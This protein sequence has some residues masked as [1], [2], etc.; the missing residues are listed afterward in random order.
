MTSK[1]F[2][3]NKRYLHVYIHSISTDQFETWWII[4]VL[5]QLLSWLT[6]H[7]ASWRVFNDS[8]GRRKIWLCDL[9]SLTT[10]ANREVLVQLQIWPCHRTSALTLRA[11]GKPA[12]GA[13]QQ[14]SYLKRE[15]VKMGWD[16][17]TKPVSLRL[18][19]MYGMTAHTGTS[20]PRF[21]ALYQGGDCA[22]K[23]RVLGRCI[24]ED[25]N[26]RGGWSSSQRQLIIPK[27]DK[28]FWF[29]DD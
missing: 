4:L 9:H 11:S 28:K 3:I 8:R 13:S 19:E 21:R 2:S 10:G 25:K 29:V 5:L 7:C 1:C 20:Y 23:M 18:S 22:L 17:M 12:T 14:E 16:G 24:R 27:T 26:L 15:G 6:H